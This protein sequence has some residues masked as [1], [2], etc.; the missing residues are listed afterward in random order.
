MGKKFLAGLAFG[1]A[2]AYVAWQSLTPAQKEELKAKVTDR[3]YDLMDFL[4]D[5]SLN[6]LDIVD[7]FTQDYS[8]KAANRFQD[9]KAT[10][11]DTTDKVTETVNDKVSQVSQQ[12][13][14]N[15]FDEEIADIRSALAGENTKDVSEGDGDIIIDQT[16]E[17]PTE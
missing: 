11:K 7:G 9:L 5:Y 16:D 1:G 15:D 12:F 4:T 3:A 13:S 17:E 14:A 6:A 2:A 8:E 10:V